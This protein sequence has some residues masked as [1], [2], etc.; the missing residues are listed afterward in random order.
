MKIIWLLMCVEFVL[1]SR[2]VLFPD[3]SQ[4][5]LGDF[6]Y[7][8]RKHTPSRVKSVRPIAHHK[9]RFRID[10]TD[11]PCVN[12]TMIFC[13][14]VANKAYPTKY[15]E[16][17]MS[18]SGT[19]IYENFFNK[20]IP[21]ESLGIRLLSTD[22]PIELCD[23]IQRLIYPQL[24]MN[25]Q[26]DWRFVINQPSYRQPIRVEICHK[27]NSKCLFNESFPAGY[28]SSC[29]QKYAK[30]PLLSLGEDGQVTSYDY[31]FPSFCQCEI[32]LKKIEHTYHR[33]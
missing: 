19:Q 23:S 24:A 30:V 20:T 27:K 11:L 13:E 21:N 25:V 31:E 18:R 7:G 5:N 16:S 29:V 12:K 14:E 8:R 15:V 4:E 9:R 6:L 10:A 3:D 1:G 2:H 32:H 33:H 26:R 28:V 22:G 17:V